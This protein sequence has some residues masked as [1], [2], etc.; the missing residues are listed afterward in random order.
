MYAAM[1][2]TLQAIRNL[3]ICEL[4]KRQP[5]L[6]DLLVSL[7]DSETTQGEG[8]DSSYGL[9]CQDWWHTLSSLTKDAGFKRLGNG[10]FSAAYSH[11]MLPGKV[12]KVGF[13][14]EDS[15][16]AYVA[17]CRMHQ[18]RAGIPTIHDVQRHASCY[19]VVMDKLDPLGDGDDRE[20]DGTDTLWNFI[21]RAVYGNDGTW[22][23]C[24]RN[25]ESLY[26]QLTEHELETLETCRMIHKFFTGIASF[27]IHSGN[28]MIDPMGRI[29]ITDP[30]SYSQPLG[31]IERCENAI[32]PEALLA[33]IEREVAK[34]A[35]EKAKRRKALRDPN[36]PE[37][38]L[39]R[40]KGK[41][42]KRTLKRRAR[43]QKAERLRK[44]EE[45]QRDREM[46]AFHDRH[47]SEVWI[48]I[49]ENND[50][51]QMRKIFHE[52]NIKHLA[53]DRLAIAQGLPLGI[54]KEL[55]AGLMG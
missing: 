54:D 45:M 28:A 15:G 39:K 14:K 9:E 47:G 1:Q 8:T 16:A 20:E 50:V 38:A 51:Q 55:Q 33:E 12:I 6:V 24:K 21:P 43:I 2:E 23:D 31:P 34:Q 7:V 3:P 29:V 27:D 52:D 25:E 13:K 46:E 37:R 18:G 5:M 19:T 53:V 42:W 40:E 41:R 44:A 30:V 10:Y 17:F 36:G 26:A 49:V 48:G 22:E 32:D 35:I 4:H 11:E